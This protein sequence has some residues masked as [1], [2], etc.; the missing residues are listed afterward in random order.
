LV[1]ELN[2]NRKDHII[3]VEDPVEIVQE[4]IGCNVTQRQ[5]GEH[6][7]SFHS[8]LKGALRED[9]DIMAIGELRDLETIEMAIS[10]SETGHLVIGTMHTSDASTTL[11]RLL[12]V[13][14]PA[15]Q[16][17]IRTSVSES[18]RGVLCQRL[19]PAKNG[20]LVLACEILTSNPAVAALIREGKMQGLRNVMETGVKDGMCLMENSVMEL[21]RSGRITAE[22]ARQNV[23]TKQVLAQITG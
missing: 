7:V 5:V 23:T 10:A 14:P 12:D 3:T 19:L 15:Q 8:A 1:N 21:W 11:N 4:S 16:T 9:P 18:L 20:G 22:T 13:F 17:Q 6:T 2:K